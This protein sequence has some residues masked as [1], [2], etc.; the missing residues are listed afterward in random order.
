MTSL[1]ELLDKRWQLADKLDKAKT[2]PEALL[3][4]MEFH[5]LLWEIYLEETK[6]EQK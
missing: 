2:Q 1:Q 6:E 5:H 4:M 3:A